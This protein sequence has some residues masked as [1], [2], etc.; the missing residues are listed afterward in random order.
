MSKPIS[1]VPD[2]SILPLQT[3]FPRFPH[4]K[5]ENTFLVHFVSPTGHT[6]GTSIS[7]VDRKIPFSSPDDTHLS[8]LVPVVTPLSLGLEL[9]PTGTEYQTCDYYSDL[10][11]RRLTVLDRIQK[12]PRETEVKT[13]FPIFT[14]LVNPSLR[15]F[16]LIFTATGPSP[17]SV[18]STTLFDSVSVL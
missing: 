10:R 3:Q 12:F 4:S 14:P 5:H 11:A 7:N 2:G 17:F 15:L 18:V 1:P 9:G 8:L 6:P 16:G 13:L